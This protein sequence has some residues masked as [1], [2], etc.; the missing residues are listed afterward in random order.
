MSGQAKEAVT[1]TVQETVETV[2][3]AGT[4]IAGTVQDQAAQVVEQ[5]VTQSAD[6]IAQVKEQASSVFVDQRDRAIAGLSGLADAL[7]ETGRTLAEKAES[8]DGA[9]SATSAIAP[10]VEEIA[11]RL[12]QSSDFLKEKDVQQLISEAERLARKQPMLFVGALFGVGVVG[13]RLLKGT[14]GSSDD[15]SQHAEQGDQESGWNAGTGWA[16]PDQSTSQT[17]SDATTFSSQIATGL[18]DRSNVGTY[19][20]GLNADRESVYG[21][22]AP[23]TTGTSS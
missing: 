9:Q 18:L 22:G 13:A 21:S 8:A 15:Q 20:N 6:T 12:S 19:D 17:P 7:R 5:A 1:Q 10:F 14:L 2:K 16:T 11:E 3:S 4:E 23:N